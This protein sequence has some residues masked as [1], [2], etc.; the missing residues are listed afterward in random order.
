[1]PRK[2]KDKKKK[3]KPSDIDI[4]QILLKD[5]QLFLFGIIDS[6]MATDLIRKMIALDRISNAPITLTIDSPGGS[7][8]DGFA[9]IDVMK[10]IG[11]PVVTIIVGQAC[12]MAGIVSVAG[13]KRAMTKH[14]IWMAHDM[15]G[16]VDGNDYTTK[17]IDRVT[18]FKKE[19]EKCDR[20]LAQHTK[21]TIDELKKARN[22]ELWFYPEECLKKGIV[23]QIIKQNERP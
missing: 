11:S 3:A 10:G 5:R 23:D 22:G 13:E 19:Q 17:I 20:F 14:S 2:K 6:K 7:V 8:D 4:D 15:A 18:F 12:S 9:I 1:M 21:L 16:G